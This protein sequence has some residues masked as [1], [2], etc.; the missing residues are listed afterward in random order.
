MF[1]AVKK[2]GETYVDSYLDKA[3]HSYYFNYLKEPIL[4]IGCGNG[5]LLLYLS[6]SNFKNVQG[7]DLNPKLADF[8]KKRNLNADTGNILN[9]KF[10]DSKFNSVLCHQIFEH[11]SI[12]QQIPAMEEI[13]RVLK[14]EGILV[15]S[16]PSWKSRNAWEDYSHVHPY[17]SNSI[18]SLFEDC[19]FE[20][21]EL[22]YI[23]Y[24]TYLSHKYGLDKLLIRLEQFIKAYYWC[25]LVIGRKIK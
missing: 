20:V 1:E 23:P 4:D 6:N 19:G 11:L 9:L 10:K 8:C 25:Y 13:S 12:D 18:R 16:V 15:V 24:G 3:M 17:T 14:E 7:I 5:D 2:K 21:L 22:V